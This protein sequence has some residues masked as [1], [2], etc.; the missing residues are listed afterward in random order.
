MPK[1][2]IGNWKA[3]FK[4]WYPDSRVCNLIATKEEREQILKNE[5]QPGKFDVCITTFEGVRI[6]ENAL[7]KFHWEYI[8]IDEAHKIKNEQSQT[9]KRIRSLKSHGRLLLTGTPL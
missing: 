6:C 4:R 3:E 9:S 5:L 8:I 7:K 2:V 1:A